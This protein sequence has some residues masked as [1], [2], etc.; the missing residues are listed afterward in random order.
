MFLMHS[1]FCPYLDKLLIVFIGDILV[2]PRNE[3]DHA[4]HLAAMSV[5][6]RPSDVCKS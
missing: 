6:E 5:I 2:Y 3:E 1:V 4:K